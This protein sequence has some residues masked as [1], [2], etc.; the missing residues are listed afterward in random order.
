MIWMICSSQNYFDSPP[1]RPYPESDNG[2]VFGKM[3]PYF[4]RT[5]VNKFISMKVR[6]YEASNAR[7]E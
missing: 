7:Y 5:K 3:F 6:A 2:G 1:L 4:V